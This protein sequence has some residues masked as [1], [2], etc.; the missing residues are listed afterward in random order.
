MTLQK[1]TGLEVPQALKP[2]SRL[3]PVC[4][5]VCVLSPSIYVCVVGQVNTCEA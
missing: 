3:T 1:H 5:C 2:L 4:V